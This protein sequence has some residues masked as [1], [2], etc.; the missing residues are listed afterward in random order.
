MP[1][2]DLDHI[3]VVDDALMGRRGVQNGMRWQSYSY[4][5]LISSDGIVGLIIYGDV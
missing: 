4:I 2:P 3:S 5:V 1:R